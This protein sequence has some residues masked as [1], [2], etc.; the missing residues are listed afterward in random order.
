MSKLFE[1]AGENPTHAYIPVY[2]FMIWGK[3]VGRK[4]SYGLLMLVPVLNIFIFSALAVDLARSFGRFSFWEF[5]AAVVGSPFYFAW[6]ALVKKADYQGPVMTQERAHLAKIQAA[7]KA[8]DDRE[9]K[10]LVRT[11]PFRKPIWQEWAESAVFAVFAATFIRLL[12]IEPYIIPTPSMEGSLMV[13]DF[14]FVSKI[15]YGMRLPETVLQLPLVH[16]RAPMGAGESY[17]E[18]PDLP[19]RRLPAVESLDRYDPVVFNMP[20]GDSV[21]IFPD[22]VYT[23]QDYK[24]GAIENANPRYAQAIKTGRVKLVTRPRDKKDLYVKRAVG[25]AGDTLQ[26]INRKLYID[27]QLQEDPKTVQFLYAIRF[28]NTPNRAKWADMGIA[29]D[30]VI[31]RGNEFLIHLS[32]QQVEQL[33]ASDPGIQIQPFNFDQARFKGNKNY[34]HNTR[35]F[36]NWTNDNYGPIWIPKAGATITLNPKNYLLYYRPIKVY[37]GNTIEQRGGKYYINGEE[38]TTYTFQQDYYWMMGDNRHNSED[39]RVWGFVPFDHVVGKPLFIWFSLRENSLA[40][41]VAWDRIFTS[42]DRK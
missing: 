41:G 33:R 8:G 3:I 38:T 27:G 16:N 24:T 6:L 18:K 39:S 36:G 21:Y 2:N 15:H 31:P 42:A 9:F 4:L 13:G 20:A 12:F 19:Y 17:L 23:D 1:K 35:Y 22:R 28:S 26:I 11:N 37:E 40:K 10:K 14:L 7:K 25:V 34:P 30:D 32:N 5:T 29:E